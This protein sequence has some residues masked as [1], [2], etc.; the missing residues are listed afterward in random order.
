MKMIHK[1]N[2]GFAKCRDMQKIVAILLAPIVVAGCAS[3]GVSSGYFDATEVGGAYPTSPSAI[4]TYIYTKIVGTPFNLDILAGAIMDAAHGGGI[5]DNISGTYP[6][7][8]SNIDLVDWNASGGSC[9]SVGD[10]NQVSGVTIGSPTSSSYGG[11]NSSYYKWTGSERGRKTYVGITASKP[12]AHARI[13]IYGKGCSPVWPYSCTTSTQCSRDGFTIRAASFVVTSTPTSAATQAAG[14]NYTMTATAVNAAGSTITT[15]TGTPVLTTTNMTDWRGSGYTIGT[16]SGS[17][18]AAVAGVSSSSFN[19]GDFGQLSIPAGAIN[20]SNYV[21]TGGAGDVASNDCV[22]NSSSNVA[23]GS[24]QYGCNIGNQTVVSTPS[25][26]AHHYAVT[27]TITPACNNKFTYFGQPFNFRMTVDALNAAGARMTRLTASAP[28]KPTMSIT[29][30]NSGGATINPVTIPAA[31]LVWS[32]DTTY[33]TSNGGEYFTSTTTSTPYTLGAIAVT[34]TRPAGLSS[35]SAAPPDYESFVLR[36]TSSDANITLCNAAVVGASTTCDSAVTALRYGVLK[37]NDGMSTSLTPATVQ[38]SAQYW[39]G[40]K[41]VTNTDDTCTTI[42]FNPGTIASSTATKPI[43]KNASTTLSSGVGALMLSATLA[44]NL[45]IR[46]G[47]SDNNCVSAT[48]GSVSV[49]NALSGYLGSL[50]CSSSYDKDPSSGIT[51]GTLR[52]TYIY[53]AEKF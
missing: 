21:T 9:G 19:Y 26:I 11:S 49:P 18:G 32:E 14:V 42:N 39:N 12:V 43:A 5:Q 4:N 1:I 44:S 33:G 28:N 46:L 6:T 3:Q 15:Y 20:D 48:S 29:Q 41:F 8:D 13:R 22:A 7:G 31:N 23:N 25:F 36:T 51:F 16:F 17:F 38:I 30:W 47:G 27:H 34:T 52:S 2:A 24:G 37:L 50:S 45:A 10:A 40:S 53:R 35:A